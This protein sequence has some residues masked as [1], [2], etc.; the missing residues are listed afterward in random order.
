VPDGILLSGGE[1][2]L[3]SDL[4]LQKERSGGT[5]ILAQIKKKGDGLCYVNYL[6]LFVFLF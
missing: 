5:A 6:R 1:M 3:G 4:S 2:P